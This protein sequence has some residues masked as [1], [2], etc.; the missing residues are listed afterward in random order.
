VSAAIGGVRPTTRAPPTD[1]VLP[2]VLFITPAAFNHVSG[3][4][5]TFSNLFR[6]WPRDRIAT[7]H[8]DATQVTTD[9]C[10]HY[11]RLGGR[12]IAN[13]PVLARLRSSSSNA[14][15][16]ASAGTGGATPGAFRWG[17]N[18]V[19]G[20]GLPERGILSPSLAAWIE[21]FR[22]DVIYTILGGIGM[23]ELVDQVQR[24]F[25]LPLVVHFMDDWQ[26]AIYRGGLL[27]I[28]QRRRMRA[29]IARLVAAATV[30]L[31]ICD[32]MCAVY[33]ERFGRPFQSFQNTVDV[34]RWSPLAKRDIAAGRPVRLLYAGSVLGFAQAASLVECCEAVAALRREGFPIM[35]DIYG[36]PAHTAPLRD[37]LPRDEA[38]RLHDVLSDDDSYFRSLA[39]ADILLLP[40]NFDA[41]SVR[42]IRLSMPTKVPSYLV[43][44]TPILVYGPT[45]TAQVD[46]A[47]SAG[48]GHVVD[49]QDRTALMT[50]IRRLAGDLA[51][52]QDLSATA[53]RVAAER[54]DSATVRIGFQA[55]LAAA[56][57]QTAHG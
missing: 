18:A 51:L 56:A 25:G 55:A 2:R 28:L 31:G 9:I 27:S 38:I 15:V 12:E 7:A 37:R 53:R 44:G 40:V 30:R 3:G 4:G 17:K 1:E 35:L 45:G 22:P 20:D 32:A 23:M 46:Y 50:A 33:S 11:Y 24:R 39:A 42:Y 26:S 21:E 36:P 6:G 5:I 47:R 43:S 8:N 19:F 48:W 14:A 16:E 29:L 34:A 41:H 49:R 54:H 13:W 52:R 10:R 57:R